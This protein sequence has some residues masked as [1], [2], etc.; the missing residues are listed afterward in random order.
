MDILSNAEDGILTLTLV[1][2]FDTTEVEK[3]QAFVEGAIDEQNFKISVNVG[4]MT[5]INSTAL[6]SLI[7]AQKRLNQYG[8]DLAIEELSGF[9]ASVFKTL[10]IDRKI[11]CFDAH[12]DSIEYLESVGAEGVGVE[13]EQHVGFQFLDTEQLGV[14]GDD[15]RVGVMR[16]IGEYGIIF[17]WENLDDLD[18][19]TMFQAGA[20]LKLGFEL[21]LYLESHVFEAEAT[22]TTAE[23]TAGGR[24]TVQAKFTSLS[25]VERRA[26]QRF[27]KDMRYLQGELS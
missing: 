26:I 23:I 2:S 8:G 14:A 20:R 11:K 15:V 4:Q 19:D 12:T 9:P 5:F 22:V 27:V 7:R 16:Q 10:G 25:D 18:V 17:G 1:G 6:G 21:P 13:G 3:F 24:V